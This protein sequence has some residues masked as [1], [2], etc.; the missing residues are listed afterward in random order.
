MEI[1]TNPDK[2][3]D[4]S[5]FPYIYHTF[6]NPRFPGGSFAVHFV[7]HFRSGN[8]LRSIAVGGH[9]RRCT[10]RLYLDNFF[11]NLASSSL[12]LHRLLTLSAS[13]GATLGPVCSCDLM[14]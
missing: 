7:D 3:P 13:L 12:E 11:L 5:G 9:L 14:S 6:T 1:R 8:H 2:R 10:S 4:L